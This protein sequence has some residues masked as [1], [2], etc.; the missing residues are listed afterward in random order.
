[1]TTKSISRIFFSI[2]QVVYGAIMLIISIV[3]PVAHIIKGTM[4]LPGAIFSISVLA[5][6]IYL[7]RLA[8]KELRDDF[9]KE[10]KENSK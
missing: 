3:W 9:N 5:I 6:S 8:W 10:H 2:H 7:G 1:M 4:N